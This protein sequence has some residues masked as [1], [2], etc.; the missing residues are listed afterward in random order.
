[1]VPKSHNTRLLNIYDLLYNALGPCHWW[2]AESRLEIII[3][4]ILTQGVSWKNVSKAIANLRATDSLNI[5]AL[6]E[7]DE[8]ILAGLIRSTLY[9][10][11][12]TRKIKTLL[13]WVDTR[14][15]GDIDRMLASPTAELRG[16]L[17]NL[18]GIG[19]ETAD[20]IL[21]Y[22]GCHPV[23]V[24]D[25]Y[26]RRIFARMGLVEENI[27]YDNMQSY[28]EAHLPRQVDLYN[29]YHALLVRLGA[30][31][32]KKKQP[33]CTYCPVLSCCAH[34]AGKEC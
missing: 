25:A 11:Q 16:E 2:P 33:R 28:L 17:L 29:E 4:A 26:T 6:K 32:C 22:A 14:Y 1:M 31:F 12:K 10:R 19:P 15:G 9:H 20:S 7:M 30:E 24:V 23:F 3:G 21:L 13:G 34:G 8:E 27:A 18:W 5:A